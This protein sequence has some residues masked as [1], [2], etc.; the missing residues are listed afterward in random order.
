MQTG[1]ETFKSTF[2]ILAVPVFSIIYATGLAFAGLVHM[3][4]HEK[5]ILVLGIKGEKGICNHK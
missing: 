5:Q 1:E 3:R 4:K 2:F